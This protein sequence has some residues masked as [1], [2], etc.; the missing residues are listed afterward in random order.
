MVE[1]SLKRQELKYF[2]NKGD[3]VQ[4]KNAMSSVMRRDA[5]SGQSG[6]YIVSSLYF[7]TLDDQ[8]LEEKLDGIHSRKKFRVRIYNKSTEVIKFETK[9]KLNTG[10]EK[11][12]FSIPDDVCEQLVKSNYTPDGA[13]SNMAESFLY[14]K[15]LGYKPRV[16]SEYRRT[17]FYLPFNEIRVTVDENLSSYHNYVDILNLQDRNSYEVYGGEIV[18]LEVKF[19]EYLPQFVKDIL[20]SVPAARSSASKYCLSQRYISHSRWTDVLTPPT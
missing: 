12:S 7:E 1:S 17:A 13:D 14:L 20:S 9:V 18:C 15:A 3:A 6:S 10:I 5:H 2:I 11:R 4:L 8:D 19:S 16:I